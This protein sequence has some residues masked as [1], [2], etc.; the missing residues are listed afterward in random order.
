[1]FAFLDEIVNLSIHKLTRNG[2]KMEVWYWLE[3]FLTDS[4]LSSFLS[5]FECLNYMG[6]LTLMQA[7]VPCVCFCLF[8][9]SFKYHTYYIIKCYFKIT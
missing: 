4:K 1:M 6:T 9:H 2:G 3:N 7:L 8:I 5:H